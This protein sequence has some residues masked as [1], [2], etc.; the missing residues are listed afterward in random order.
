MRLAW[1]FGFSQQRTI[2]E[3][4]DMLIKAGYRSKEV[5]VFV[6]CNWKISWEE[7]CR[8]LDLLKIWNVKINDCWF[9]NQ[10]SP[11]IEPKFWTKEQIFD[12]RGKGDS[13]C[14]KHNLMIR[15]RFDPTYKGA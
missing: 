1:D 11:N 13:R 5:S 3:R 8:K 10:I 4:I 2:K 7:C 14:R 9:D 12:F 6:I 15:F